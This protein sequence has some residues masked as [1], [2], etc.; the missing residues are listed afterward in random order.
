[1]VHACLREHSSTSFSAEAAAAFREGF[2]PLMLRLVS[3][4]RGWQ[5]GVVIGKGHVIVLAVSPE[6]LPFTCTQI[7][8]LWCNNYIYVA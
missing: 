4:G 8:L 5:R 1:M 3:Y 2:L 7:Q 6:Q